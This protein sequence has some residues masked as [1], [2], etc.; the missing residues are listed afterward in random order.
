MRFRLYA[1][2]A[3]C[4]SLSACS[5]DPSL[6]DRDA[7]TRACVISA[8]C[9]VQQ[10]PSVQGCVDFYF[11]VQVPAGLGRTNGEIYRCVLD[12]K[13]SCARVRACFGPGDAC[14][15]SYVGHC[16]GGRAISCDLLD[17]RVYAQNCGLSGLRCAAGSNAFAAECH[18]DDNLSRCEGGWALRCSGGQVQSEHCAASGMRCEGGRCVPPANA[19]ACETPSARC[20]GEIA[21][22]CDGK[23][24]LRIDC[25]ALP[26]PHSCQQ[27]SCVARSLECDDDFNRCS[28]EG[29]LEA[30]II[31]RWERFDCGSLGFDI[32][33]AQD[34]GANCLNL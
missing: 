6:I 7:L 9:G 34:H 4:F 8:A 20:D 11:D 29:T 21:L 23:T 16:E 1:A 30:C 31:G 10:R 25:A 5:S 12:A 15:N 19:T 26:V 3:L 13:G 14:D 27:G 32:C 24:E 2:L 22:R 33:F 28:G 18:C 17:K